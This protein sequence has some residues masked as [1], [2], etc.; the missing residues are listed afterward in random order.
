MSA[1]QKTG[2]PPFTR[3][4]KNNEVLVIEPSKLLFRVVVNNYKQQEEPSPD[5]NEPIGETI[6]DDHQ[7]LPPQP[8][9][10]LKFPNYD[11]F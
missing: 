9:G 1:L 3:I 6:M 7:G 10:Y 11:P 5:E 2:R 4:R 8:T